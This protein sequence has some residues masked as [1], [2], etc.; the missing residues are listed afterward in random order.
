[1]SLRLLL[2]IKRRRNSVVSQLSQAIPKL[3][4]TPLVINI[5]RI[6]Q[7]AT[8]FVRG[9]PIVSTAIVG[10][11]TTGLATAIAVTRRARSSRKKRTTKKKSTKKRKTTRTRKKRTKAEIKAMRLKNLAKARRARKKG[12]SK[13]RI[14]RGRGLGRGEIKHSGR[15]TKGKHKVVKFRGKDG[16]IVRFKARK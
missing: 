14:I 5:E 9:N 12:S 16:K 11:G 4:S 10:A 1:V 15:G 7:P 13:R 6:L 3:R 2:P 8:D